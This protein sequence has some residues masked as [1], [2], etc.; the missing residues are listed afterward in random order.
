MGKCHMR[1]MLSRLLLA[2]VLAPLR[3]A[4]R[5]TKRSTGDVASL[6]PRLIAGTPAGVLLLILVSVL[7][8]R[9]SISQAA[10]D[11]SRVEFNRQIRPLLA[12]RCFRCHGP[13]ARH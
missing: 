3:G 8:S 10:D 5:Q 12:D 1:V 6:N 9:S 13:D 7:I 2:A 4:S 11:D